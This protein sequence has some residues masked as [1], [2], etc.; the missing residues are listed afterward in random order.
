MS[1]FGSEFYLGFPRILN[2]ANNITFTIHTLKATNVQFSITTTDSGWQ[3]TG[4]TTANNPAVVDIPLN[5]EVLGYSYPFRN[6]GL[7]I[8]SLETEPISIIGWSY[9]AQYAYMTYL[10][11]PCHNQPTNK[12]V[13]YGVST[14]GFSNFYSTI[15]IVAC[16][17]NTN[18]TVV[19]S[20]NITLPI[21]P[22]SLLSATKL[23]LS[24][25]SHNFV[26]NAGQ[27]LLL[28]KSYVDL[29]GTKI[30]ADGPLSVLSGHS[31]SQIPLGITDTDPIVTQL[32]PT[33]TWGKTFLL[34][35]QP[36]K[37]N[38]QF[39]KV[40]AYLN[41][42]VITKKCNSDDP[43]NVTLTAGEVYQFNT[44]SSTYCSIISNKPIYIAQIGPSTFFNGGHYGDP[45]LNTIPPI[46]QYMHSIEFSAFPPS[47]SYFSVVIPND[48]YFN[49]GI[50]YNG[51]TYNLTW[52]NIYFPN[53]SIAGYGFNSGSVTGA[54]T[55]RHT[56]PQG[57]IFVSIC[58]WTTYGGYC[59][60]G[61]MKLNPINP[62][63]PMAEVSFTKDQFFVTEGSNEVLITLNKT[64]NYEEEVLV[65]MRVSPL[66]V[67]TAISI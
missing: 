11:L 6:L 30:I 32:T 57:N 31:L 48:A 35:P 41:A 26:L 18:I 64:V 13:Y 61:G 54:N 15:L 10:A 67:D 8:S 58:G 44:S 34:S 1:S 36:G 45:T 12:Y 28:Y 46:E 21:N 5:Y 65:R 2:A 4:T 7:H 14:Y 37:P 52:T 22:Q 16:K 50:V 33:I 9:V 51:I 59:Y 19:P 20:Q 39:Y 56:H 63:P 62:P 29:S 3:Y 24:G 23:F 47:F 27:T 49:Q 40:V 60:T 38:G 42:T 25:E 53:G 66:S 43:V 55:I 17:N